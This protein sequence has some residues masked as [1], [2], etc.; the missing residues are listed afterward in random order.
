[1]CR[2]IARMYNRSRIVDARPSAIDMLTK[3]WIYHL[4][5]VNNRLKHVVQVIKKKNVR[6]KSDPA[7]RV[8]SP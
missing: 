2:Y 3:R 7:L 6:D 5:G 1:M 4:N 8:D